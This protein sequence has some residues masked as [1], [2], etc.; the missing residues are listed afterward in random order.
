[1]ALDQLIDSFHAAWSAK[2]RPGFEPAVT[3]DIH[4][5]DPLTPE[6]L[7]GIAALRK[8][9]ER[10]WMGFPDARVEK[11]GEVLTD[12]HFVC[13]PAKLLGTHAGEMEGLPETG[14]FLV[15]HAVFYCELD[16]SRERLSRVR[17]FYDAYG[18]AMQLG[19][20]PKHGSLGEKAL[21]MIRGF[22]VRASGAGPRIGR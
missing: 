22:G 8:H 15:V 3:A 2:K 5:E 11:T 21:L 4:Y 20:L 18:A 17:A 19:L 12:G 16:S 9:A 10:L 1:M 6:P 7:E 13:A 14:R